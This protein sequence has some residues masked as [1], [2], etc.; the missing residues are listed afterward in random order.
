MVEK[1]GDKQIVVAIEELSEL[2]KELCKTLRS[3]PNPQNILEELADCHIVL[4]EMQLLFNITDVDLI[5]QINKKVKRTKQRYIDKPIDME[6][7]VYQRMCIGC[8]R[9]R[10]C[11]EHCEHCDEYEDA[12]RGEQD[13]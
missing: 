3:Q 1:Y 4:Q 11:H 7:E 12:L 5:Q 9:E 8:E 13:E 10:Y 6:W 2:T